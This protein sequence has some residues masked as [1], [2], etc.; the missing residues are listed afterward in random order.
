M[1][2][3]S[4]NQEKEEVI[5]TVFSKD[6]RDK[7]YEECTIEIGGIKRVNLSPHNLLEWLE[8]NLK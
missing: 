8:F 7:F 2:N 6:F 1:I 3:G 4:S 5:K